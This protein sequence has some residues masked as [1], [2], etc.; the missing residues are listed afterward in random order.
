MMKRMNVL[1]F[2]AL[3]LM[4]CSEEE[5]NIV[6]NNTPNIPQTSI[7]FPSDLEADW[8]TTPVSELEWNQDAI[9]PLKEFL[10]ENNTK[11][12]MIL[13]NGRIVM[14][15]Y[16]NGHSATSTWK[17]NSAGKT[18][19][20][21]TVGIAQQENLLNIDDKASDY[22]GTE[23][24]NM[25]L[26]KENLISVNDLLTMTSGIDNTTTKS[27]KEQLNLCF[28]RWYKVGLRKRFSK[29]AGCSQRI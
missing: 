14:E 7:Y 8:E 27:S 19:A 24:T 21:A 16:F 13:I 25:P 28:G 6:E 26:E 20:T 10:I 4:S 1:I 12:F 15:E 3:I 11:S 18:L 9:Q 23:W 2:I 22:L 17:W 29:T 5:D